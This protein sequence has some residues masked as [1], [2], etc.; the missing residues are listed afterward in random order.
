MAS[1]PVEFLYPIRS[2][3]QRVLVQ[4]VMY[5]Y[6]HHGTGRGL[7]TMTTIEIRAGLV[8]GGIAKAR[9]MNVSRALIEAIPNVHQVNNYELNPAKMKWELTDTGEAHVQKLLRIPAGGQPEAIHDVMALVEKL[10]ESQADEG[11]QGYIEEALKCLQVDALRASVVFL[12]TGAVV[13]LQE[14]ALKSSKKKLN[15][16]IA[17]H[18]PKAREVK[19]MDDFAYIKDKTL[20]LACGELGLL[21]KGERTTLEEALS[22]RNRCGHPTK[23]QPRAAR[24][25]AF[26]EDVVGVVFP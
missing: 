6:K 4:A 22:L 16:A 24:A 12:W 18:D 13:I 2:A 7:R 19:K 11:V 9:K 15:D 3:P 14:K 5:Y 10:A 26:I 20:L 8:K 21:D 17:K 23:Y 1:T 25:G